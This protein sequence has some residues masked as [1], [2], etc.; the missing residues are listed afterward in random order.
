M[1]DDL[2][3]LIIGGYLVVGATAL[4]VSITEIGR[5]PATAGTA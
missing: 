1:R 3:T 4:G 2:R 5:S